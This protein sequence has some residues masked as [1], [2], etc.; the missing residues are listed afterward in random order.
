VKEKIMNNREV[1]QKLV[2]I[3][4]RWRQTPVVDD[5]F[6]GLKNEFDDM[7]EEAKRHLAKPRPLVVTLCGS[8]RFYK[9]FQEANYR[10]TMA[11]RI[12][13]SVG[14]YPHTSQRIVKVDGCMGEQEAI[15]TVQHGEAT[16]CTPEEKIALD[17]LHLQKIDLSDEVLILNVGGYIGESTASELAHARRR[18]KVIRFLENTV[19]A[20]PAAR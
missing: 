6:V 4:E 9:E 10:E 18:G 15:V 5:D 14:H 3:G 1:L 2:A 19:D 20:G 11:G 12:V 13:L 8:T 7:L 17:K 16:G